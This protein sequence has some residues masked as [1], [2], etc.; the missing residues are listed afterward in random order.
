MIKNNDQLVST[1]LKNSSFIHTSENLCSNNQLPPYSDAVLT[2]WV[3][4]GVVVEP[5][6][7]A[8]ILMHVIEACAYSVHFVF[9]KLVSNHLLHFC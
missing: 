9:L 5:D 3:V 6:V 1:I 4:T 7:P 2:S 8:H